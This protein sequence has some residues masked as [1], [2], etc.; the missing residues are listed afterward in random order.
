MQPGHVPTVT[1][2]DDADPLTINE[3]GVGQHLLA[4]DTVHQITFTVAL[5]I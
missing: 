2:A 5:V 3:A 1:A 4:G